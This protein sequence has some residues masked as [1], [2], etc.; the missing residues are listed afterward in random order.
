M[1]SPAT[2][3]RLASPTRSSMTPTR[4]SLTPTRSSLT[5]TRNSLNPIRSSMPRASTQEERPELPRPA[6]SA[7]WLAR[8][9]KAKGLVVLDCSWYLPGSG[10][11]PAREFEAERI[12][13]ARFF[14][15]DASCDPDSPL[16]HTLPTPE[17]F[18]ARA[19]ATGVSDSSSVVV[20]DASGV[21]ISAPRVWWTFRCFGFDNIAVLDGGFKHWKASGLPVESGTNSRSRGPQGPPPEFTPLVRSELVWS[22]E[23]M[24]RATRDN[25]VEVVDARPPGRFAGSEPEPRAGL[26]LGHVPGS[27]NLPYGKLVYGETGLGVD[28]DALSALLR[29]AGVDPTK[30][31]VATC[32]S[33]TSACAVAWSMARSGRWDVA[34]YDGS[35]SEWGSREDLPVETGPASPS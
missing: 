14:D 25:A 34:V 21:N 12:P 23:Q 35:W 4:S 33:G 5:P 30:K 2:A 22:V 16:P 6:V 10:R 27:R 1:P 28:G 18:K 8:N 9:L 31:M 15:L 26:R 24:V 17:R 19:E 7:A 29:D 3:V 13:G 11:D 32:G 20:Y